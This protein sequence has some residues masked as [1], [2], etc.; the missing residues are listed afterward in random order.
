M[1]VS[2][3]DLRIVECGPACSYTHFEGS[4]VGTRKGG[5]RE[6]VCVRGVAG[7]LGG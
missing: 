4:G 3:A 2:L 6:R 1:L 7:R 5:A